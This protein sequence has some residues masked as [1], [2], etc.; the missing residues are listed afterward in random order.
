MVQACADWQ[1]DIGAYLVGALDERTGAT[2]T[3]HLGS[4]AGCRAEFHE[5]APVRSWLSLL[6]LRQP[7]PHHHRDV[8]GS[9]APQ[10][11]G[12]SLTGRP[13][14]CWGP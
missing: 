12:C 3:Q 8:P 10:L 6:M 4:C 7:H 9:A 2:V 14:G 5:L 13:R 11:P 1:G